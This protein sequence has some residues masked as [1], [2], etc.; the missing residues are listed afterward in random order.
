MASFSP[1]EAA[2]TGFGV[3]RRNPQAVLIWTG[4]LIAFELA[5]TYPLISL[6]G[7]TIMELQAFKPTGS[8]A[9][10]PAILAIFGK[11]APLLPVIV[12]EG[13]LTRGVVGAM[14]NRVV[15][16]PTDSA[17]GFLRFG[18]DEF[19]QIGLSLFFVAVFIGAYIAVLIATVVILVIAGLLGKAVGEIWG[20]LL[21]FAGV[22]A[23]LVFIVTALIRLSLASALTFDKQ[24]VDLFGSWALTKGHAWSILGAHFLSMIMYMFV[25]VIGYMV[26]IGVALAIGGGDLSHMFRQ[27]MSSVAAYFTPARFVQLVLGGAL[28]AIAAPILS[29]VSPA[30]Y[31]ALTKPEY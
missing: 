25:L 18:A 5:A 19:R 12:L 30:I 16:K 21:G 2:L 24:R 6:Y 10:G 20:A 15:L 4:L 17:F 11:L 27:D 7:P 13:L 3:V 9:D 31:Q 28:S 22:M 8:A 29:T 14:M 26:V 23:E 1:S